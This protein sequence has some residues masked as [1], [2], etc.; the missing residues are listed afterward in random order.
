MLR[1]L[2]ERWMVAAPN[3]RLARILV[4]D[5]L[6]TGLRSGALGKSLSTPD[7]SGGS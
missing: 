2:Y 3:Y 6:V 4:H 7:H 5:G 1:A